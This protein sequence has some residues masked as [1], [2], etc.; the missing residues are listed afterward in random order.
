MK[1]SIR[2]L[3]TTMINLLKE[4]SAGGLIYKVKTINSVTSKIALLFNHEINK[5][6]THFILTKNLINKKNINLSVEYEILFQT[7]LEKI[8]SIFFVKKVQIINNQKDIHYIVKNLPNY[9]LYMQ[10]QKIMDDF[11]EE[12]KKNKFKTDELLKKCFILN[13]FLSN[14]DE[15]SESSEST[16]NGDGDN[17]SINSV[18]NVENN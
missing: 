16:E 18:N 13:S 2:I 6:N 8:F 14:D 4:I 15:E 17:I 10:V 11:Y 3:T 5:F 12:E 7:Y 1:N 9:R